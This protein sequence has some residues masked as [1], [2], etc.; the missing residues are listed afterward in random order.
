MRVVKIG[1]SLEAAPG[2]RPLLALL[3]DY[4]HTG[5]IIAPGGGRFADRVRAEQRATGMDDAD[6]HRLAIRAMEQYAALLCGMEPRL[7]PI[8]DTSEISG[9][10]GESAVPV[11]LP[12]RLLADEPGI[13]ANWKVTS[14]SLALWFAGKVNAEA[15]ILVKSVPNNT[16]D[17]Q[18]LAAT[19]YLDEYFPEMMKKTGLGIIAC[20][21]IDE[22]EI[23]G[24]AL[25]SGA[26]PRELR[27]D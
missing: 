13:P 8:S 23:L 24:K 10:G 20:L 2:L 4:G 6:A 17:A 5:V 26:I 22:Q 16:S 3:A 18:T 19:G 11:W 1:G 9:A 15:L 27:T 25:A 14:D 21:G 12:A 7:Y